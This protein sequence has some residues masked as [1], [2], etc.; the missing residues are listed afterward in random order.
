MLKALTT[1]SYHEGF[2]SVKSRTQN[3][4]D[5]SNICYHLSW[6]PGRRNFSPK[7]CCHVSDPERKAVFL[8]CVAIF[9]KLRAS[10]QRGKL[11]H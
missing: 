7:A 10:L 8:S 9:S 2:P 1:D 4:G 11:T 3:K 6:S 5:K